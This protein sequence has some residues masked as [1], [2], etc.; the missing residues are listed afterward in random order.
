MNILHAVIIG[1]VEGVTEFLPISSTAH[2]LITQELLGVTTSQTFEIAVQGGAMLAVIGLYL[3]EITSVVRDLPKL[4]VAFIPTALVGVAIFPYLSRLYDSFWV[5]G[6][7]LLVGGVIMILLPKQRITSED[8]EQHRALSWRQ[9]LW[10]GCAQ[11]CAVIPGVSRSGGI[12]VAGELLNIPRVA[13]VRFSFLLGAGTIFAA[14]AYS[15]MR[16]SES[17]Q[18]ILSLPFVVAFLVAGLSAWAV[19]KWL[20]SYMS[21]ASLAL[22]GWYRVLLGLILIIFLV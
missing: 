1:L 13:L 7:V 20:L 2:I 21:H 22:F 16:S 15:I 10:I 5:I 18:G 9:S 8:T 3:S 6:V 14:S 4:L 11:A 12:F 17:L 19:C